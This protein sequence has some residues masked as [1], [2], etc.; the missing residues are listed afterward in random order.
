MP[1]KLTVIG[2]GSF[3]TAMAK[4]VSTISRERNDVM[5]YCEFEEQANA[6]NATH[7]NPLSMKDIELGENISAVGGEKNLERA[8][9]FSDTAILALPSQALGPVAQ[10]ISAVTDSGAGFKFLSLAKGI[11]IS[12]GLF[13]HQLAG[14][15]LPNAVYSALS[16]PSHAEEVALGMP[17]AV[18]VASK[19]EPTALMW[20]RALNDERLRI[21]TSNDVQGVELGG[22][23]K[24]VIAIAVGIARAL[25]FG[26][27]SVAALVTRGLA[28]IMRYGMSLGANSLTLAGLAGI[29][30]LMVT[31]YSSL[32]RN[33]RFGNAVGSGKTPDEA[34]REIGQVVEG[35]HTVRALVAKAR[36]SN[37]DLP[38]TEGVYSVLYDNVP[39]RDVLTTLLTREPKP[40][41]RV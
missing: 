22:S 6:I 40:E 14:K 30:D 1:V 12:S 15:F 25:G 23:M 8:L 38:I 34:A 39:V 4:H 7:R 9:S 11:E 31:C 27:N 20:Q 32:S 17:S 29:G 3:G 35:M 19:D 18:V 37:L 21:Y 24:N 10:K 33:F 36:E 26:D 5:L 2:A 13:M 16:G 28:E 41:I